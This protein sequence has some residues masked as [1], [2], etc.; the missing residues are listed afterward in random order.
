[1]RQRREWEVH[2]KPASAKMDELEKKKISD[3]PQMQRRKDLEN[4]L[5]IMNIWK[6][7]SGELD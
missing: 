5:K 4:K 7:Q 6:E 1:M 3:L 2:Q